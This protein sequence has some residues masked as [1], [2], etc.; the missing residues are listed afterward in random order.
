MNKPCIPGSELISPLQDES[1]DRPC[2]GIP[3]ATRQDR[4]CQKELFEFQ[5]SQHGA[6][7][8]IDLDLV[9]YPHPAAR[10]AQALSLAEIL[11]GI[12]QSAHNPLIY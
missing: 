7:I 10:A 8:V 5:F 4:T 11:V 6:D 1:V 12:Y 2:R 9:V 3:P